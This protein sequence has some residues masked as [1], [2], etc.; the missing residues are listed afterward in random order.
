MTGNW[1]D[2]VGK[3]PSPRSLGHDIR[4]V[5][6]RPV[7]DPLG[8]HLWSLYTQAHSYTESMRTDQFGYSPTMDIARDAVDSSREEW[9]EQKGFIGQNDRDERKEAE[10]FALAYV[11]GQLRPE[12]SASLPE[13]S[14]RPN[15]VPFTL[16][17]TLNLAAFEIAER[18]SYLNRAV[19]EA[20]KALAAPDIS[21]AVASELREQ[22]ELTNRQLVQGKSELL[23]KNLRLLADA[24]DRVALQHTL[25]EDRQE[26][27]RRITELE[28]AGR[29]GPLPERLK[30]SATLDVLRRQQAKLAKHVP[31]TSAQY[32]GALSVVRKAPEILN[33]AVAQLGDPDARAPSMLEGLLM[34]MRKQPG[35][36][37][38]EMPEVQALKLLKDALAPVLQ[39]IKGS[40][41]T[42]SAGS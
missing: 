29:S 9:H 8:R 24:L 13:I 12:D 4:D 5:L 17:D 15:A 16:R 11:R 1:A 38:T 41:P 19:E 6:N 35:T 28:T 37:T 18:G 23:G 10:D 40:G 26:T 31:L 32:E 3:S 36:S 27:D 25:E 2:Q 20:E 22:L 33:E 30:R 14:S 7:E 39:R 42:H 21:P 34:V